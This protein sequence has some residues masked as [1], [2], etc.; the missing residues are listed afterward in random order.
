[1]SKRPLSPALPNSRKKHGHAAATT[2]PATTHQSPTTTAFKIYCDLDG[3]LVDFGK[4]VHQVCGHRPEHLSKSRMWSLLAKQDGF[5]TNLPWMKGGRELWNAIRPLG[6]DILTGVPM[7]PKARVEKA[8]WCQREL[9]ISTNHVDMAGHKS[10]HVVV[11]GRK[12]HGMT[13]VITCWSKNKH[14]EVKQQYSRAVL[15]DDRE[16]L[17]IMWERAGGIFIHHTPG[18]VEPTLT[19]LKEHGI[20]PSDCDNNNSNNTPGVSTSLV[21]R[22]SMSLPDYDLPPDTP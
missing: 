13:N 19:K 22:S 17:G 3:V 15:I 10:T 6:P 8:L 9:G 12:Q 14:H 5:Y 18:H 2:T 7:Y 20:L 21:T 4:G 11:S 16:E 1:M